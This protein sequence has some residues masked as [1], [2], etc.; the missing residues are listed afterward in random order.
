[1]DGLVHAKSYFEMD[2]LRVPQFQETTTY[3]YSMYI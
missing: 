3:I 1:M 2:D